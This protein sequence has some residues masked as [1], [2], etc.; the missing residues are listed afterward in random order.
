MPTRQN[1]YDLLIIGSGSASLAF[2]KAA[3]ALK[4]SSGPNNCLVVSNDSHPGGTCV[5]RGCVPKKMFW[6]EASHRDLLK[7]APWRF[8]SPDAKE[9][10]TPTFK[11]AE[12]KAA[13]DDYI[14]SLSARHLKSLEA[15]EIEFFRGSVTSLGL[16]ATTKTVTIAA[17]GSDGTF[18][19]T[20]S[21]LVITT[22]S[23]PIIPPSLSCKG[24]LT[25]D[26]FF[27]QLDEQPRTMAV[28]GSGYIALELA[29]LMN[30]LGTKV[31]LMIRT[32]NVL[33]SFDE[34]IQTEVMS[35]LLLDG[36]SVIQCNVVD[37]V[38]CGSGEG[39]T[40]PPQKRVLIDQERSI[41]PFE[42][43]LWAIGRI[44]NLPSLDVG[45]MPLDLTANKQFLDTDKESW[46]CLSNQKPL[47]DV[48]AIGD[49]TGKHMLTP[50]AIAVA[51]RVVEQRFA[52]K[53]GRR[54]K[55]IQIVPSVLFTHPPV[56][57]IG[58]TTQEAIA[59]HGPS[60]VKVFEAQFKPLKFAFDQRHAGSGTRDSNDT[61]HQTRYR[62]VCLAPANPSEGD[63]DNDKNDC[64][65]LGLH[66]IG[67]GSDE[68]LQGFA[69]ALQ[70]G[71]TKRDFEE[72]VA[73]HPTSIEEVLHL[74]Y[75]ELRD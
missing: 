70:A 71:A 56:G 20:C 41:G 63:D 19:V 10:G 61:R 17:P 33:T 51:R 5:F 32:E 18:R 60:R 6:Y 15:L 55:P 35:R 73:I 47:E 13:R 59:K 7:E 72:T 2:G 68:A 66:M 53:T 12:F 67:P 25:S 21:V 31:T 11:W 64:Q 54:M 74:K 34:M 9:Q 75:K 58:L 28:I 50:Y 39:K 30:I 29:S 3:V 26:S 43:V 57:T 36:V 8:W 16:D 38:E 65:I 44:G 40:G 24:C 46:L 62:L 37:V 27:D 45:S 52:P 42:Q 4:S 23:H 22:G 69:V 48:Y 49:I 1:H 14:T